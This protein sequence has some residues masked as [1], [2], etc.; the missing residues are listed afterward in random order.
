[1]V[2][3]YVCMYITKYV[4]K[5]KRNATRTTKTTKTINNDNI[6]KVKLKS[7]FGKQFEQEVELDMVEEG[8]LVGTQ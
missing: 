2:C 3:T 6:Y 8:G 7:Q 5:L 1:M 4:T